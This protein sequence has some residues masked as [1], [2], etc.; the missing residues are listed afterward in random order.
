MFLHMCVLYVCTHKMMNTMR[1]YDAYMMHMYQ[2]HITERLLE[3]A[4]IGDG[5]GFQIT[6]NMALKHFFKCLRICYGNLP[7]V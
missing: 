5:P 1:L 6:S 3:D 7:L 4:G 2:L